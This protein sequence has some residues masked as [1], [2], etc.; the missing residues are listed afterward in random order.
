MNDFYKAIYSS[1]A[2]KYNRMVAREDYQGVSPAPWKR[3]A[4]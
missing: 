2:E 3:C 4:R 1:Q